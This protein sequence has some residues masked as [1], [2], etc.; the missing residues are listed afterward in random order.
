MSLRRS[1]SACP[2]RSPASASTVINSLSRSGPGAAII[3]TY[4]SKLAARGSLSPERGSACTGLATIAGRSSSHGI[5]PPAGST[6][7]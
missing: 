3:A 6:T 4:S 1:P 5:D 2:I 7:S